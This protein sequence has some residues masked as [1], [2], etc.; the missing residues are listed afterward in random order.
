MTLMAD[1]FP[2]LHT[3]KAWLSKYLKS[4]VSEYPSRSNRVRVPNT[5]ETW[6][7]ALLPYLLITVQTIETE[8]VSLSD[9]ENLRTV[10]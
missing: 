2:K 6:T 9:M 4:P 7:T 10:C 1:V 5:V 8:K 3:G